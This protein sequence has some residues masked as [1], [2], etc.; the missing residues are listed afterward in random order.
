MPPRGLE[1]HRWRYIIKLL[2]RTQWGQ[3]SCNSWVVFYKN[4]L[5]KERNRNSKLSKSKCSE[6]NFM[7]LKYLTKWNKIQPLNRQTGQWQIICSQYRALQ[8]I[9]IPILQFSKSLFL[10]IEEEKK[11]FL[12]V[13]NILLILS[14]V[15]WNY[16]EKNCNYS[17]QI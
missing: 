16:K 11:T 17:K 1:Y 15:I 13:E 6:I 2:V 7:H 3:E 8:N 5:Y 14:A 10:F 9:W 4:K 12:L